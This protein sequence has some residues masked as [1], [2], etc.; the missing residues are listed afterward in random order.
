MTTAEMNSF[1]ATTTA[2]RPFSDGRKRALCRMLR[3]SRWTC[4]RIARAVNV[5]PDWVQRSIK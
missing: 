3:S 5:T 1:L 4:K 2:D